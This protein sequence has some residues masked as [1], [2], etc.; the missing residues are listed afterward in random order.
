MAAAS[1]GAVVVLVAIAGIVVVIEHCFS[2][3]PGILGVY[4][5]VQGMVQFPFQDS[6]L[7]VWIA[8]KHAIA[9]GGFGIGIGIGIVAVA[10]I[11]REHGFSGN[12]TNGLI[13]IVRVGGSQP[14]HNCP[15]LKGMAT[16]VVY[17]KFHELQCQGTN[18][19]LWRNRALRVYLVVIVAVVL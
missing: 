19:I 4:S 14:L 3:V 18:V 5:L 10:V 13:S 16:S 1:G 11:E 9:C 17:G 12:R 6:S 15:P 8:S 7:E 2:L